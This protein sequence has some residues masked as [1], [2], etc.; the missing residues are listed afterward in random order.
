MKI[1]LKIL[2]SV[3]VLTILFSACKPNDPDPISIEDQQ[4][5]KLTA[6]WKLST[7]TSAT[8]DGTAQKGYDNFVLTI[9]GTAGATS[10]GYT[11]AGRPSNSPWPPSGTWVFGANPESQIVRDT[12]ADKLDMT[13]SV[14]GTEL[15][16]T[17]NFSGVG[18]PSSRVSN[19][20]GQWVF[21]FKK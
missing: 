8:L 12:G 21:T 18:Y 16:V 13:Y 5:E 7:P 10:F 6:S 19:V 11:A 4:L 3:L 15:Q 17:F 20:K 14:S 1:T 9:S 2:A